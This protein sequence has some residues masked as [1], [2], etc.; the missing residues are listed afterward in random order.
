MK[1]FFYSALHENSG[2]TTKVVKV[3]SMVVQPC[4]DSHWRYP[5]DLKHQ[6]KFDEQN[7]VWNNLFLNLFSL[8]QWYITYTR[9]TF[10]FIPNYQARSLELWKHPVSSFKVTLKNHRK[11][12]WSQNTCSLSFTERLRKAPITSEYF[13]S[14]RKS[15]FAILAALFSISFLSQTTQCGILT[16]YNIHL[17]YWGRP[18]KQKH[19]AQDTHTHKHTIAT[20]AGKELPLN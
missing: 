17:K 2:T 16:I 4:L 13:K 7:I 18:A 3:T 14:W 15:I 9:T 1:K 12:A 8:W 10:A 5:C 20:L 6:R 11:K 19:S